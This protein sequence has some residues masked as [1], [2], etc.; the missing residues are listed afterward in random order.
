MTCYFRRLGEVFK[1][2]GIDVN[3][4]NK[5]EIDT[6]IHHIVGVNY[7]NCPLVWRE[8]KHRI[9]EDEASFI[10]ILKDKWS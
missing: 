1:K 3:P 2:A 8:V 6:I 10:S 7:K 5:K 9:S 4:G